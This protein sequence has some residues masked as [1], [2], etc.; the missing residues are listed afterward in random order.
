M[1]RCLAE[2]LRAAAFPRFS[3]RRC[4]VVCGSEV[5]VVAAVAPALGGE[6][7]KMKTKLPTLLSEVN[8]REIVEEVVS[9]TAKSAAAGYAKDALHGYLSM[10]L[11]DAT[12]ELTGAI[13][14]P[15]AKALLAVALGA[16]DTA[17]ASI[18]PL[19]REPYETGIRIAREAFSIQP[20]TV[21]DSRL[22][23]DQLRSAIESLDRAYSLTRE[24][25]DSDNEVF[26]IRLLQALCARELGSDSYAR[27]WLQECVQILS[28][29][30]QVLAAQAA[31][32]RTMAD[33]EQAIL[34]A[35]QQLSVARTASLI[36][37]EAEIEDLE[38]RATQSRQNADEVA[39][40]IKMFEAIGWPGEN[41]GGAPPRKQAE[42]SGRVR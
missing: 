25:T 22:Q 10:V 11:L 5:Y 2:F 39:A 14:G 35:A 32:S 21:E 23:H 36:A 13:A 40:L 15:L 42:N 17:A 12:G 26:S 28:A 29:R 37:I 8:W 34:K 24:G 27:L 6:L 9:S 30:W 31:A 41:D 16:R 18:V 38:D 3:D 33:K 4:Y 1:L 7:F 20:L 19:V